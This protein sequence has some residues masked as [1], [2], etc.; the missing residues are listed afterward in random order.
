M[1]AVLKPPPVVI[2]EKPSKPFRKARTGM[3]YI[4]GCLDRWGRWYF[5]NELALSPHV[6]GFPS[7]DSVQSFLEGRCGFGSGAPIGYWV[8]NIRMPRRISDV[9]G[10]VMKLPSA[11]R[12][13]VFAHYA[14]LRFEP[15]L[16]KKLVQERSIRRN[17]NRGR[18]KLV[19]ALVTRVSNM[20]FNS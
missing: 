4:D 20:V 5:E 19:G 14:V 10:Q 1:S 15:H 9:H 6:A 8:P 11:Q 2:E 7:M 18:R 3:R 13:A 12:D 16:R 17:L